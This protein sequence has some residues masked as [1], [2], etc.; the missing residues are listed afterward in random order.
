MAI[1]NVLFE[2]A[3]AL[4]HMR[5]R[6][7]GLHVVANGRVVRPEVTGRVHRFRLER[8]ACAVRLVSRS[9]VPAAVRVDSDDHRRLGVA[10]ARIVLDGRVIPLADAR[11]GAGWHVFEA[12]GAGGG[13]RWTDGNAGLDVA[14]A[15]VLE[16]AV[17]MTER[18]WL[19]AGRANARTA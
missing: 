6:D 13:W 4:G 14:G 5:T 7:A 19:T 8:M 15:G 3:E 2:C 11:L 12:D 1:R 9:A 10:V 17:A 18:Y 16:V